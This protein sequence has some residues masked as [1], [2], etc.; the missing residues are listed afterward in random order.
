MHVIRRF[1]FPFFSLTPAPTNTY[2]L[3]RLEEK[4]D[5]CN[6]VLC[7]HG[8]TLSIMMAAMTPGGD[9]HQHGTPT[10]QFENAQLKNVH[11]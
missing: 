2:A 5:G 8:D 3:Q 4:H 6:I 9:L 10:Y 11:S 1:L 7:S